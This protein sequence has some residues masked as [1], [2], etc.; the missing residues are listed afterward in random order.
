MA[1]YSK[2][3]IVNSER[4]F[5]SG[6]E[7]GYTIASFK[8]PLKQIEFVIFELHAVSPPFKRRRFELKQT[9]LH[10]LRYNAAN[11]ILIGDFNTA[12]YSPYFKRL[13]KISGLKNSMLGHGITGTWPSFLPR[14]LRIPIDHVLISDQIEI[15]R[16]D[17]VF[18]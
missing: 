5:F 16:R 11:K 3:P 14:P 4:I 12:P 9:A 2:I 10:I 17:V 6:H 13:Q 15:L 7:N 18:I 1:L 8:T